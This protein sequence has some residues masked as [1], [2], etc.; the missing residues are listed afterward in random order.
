VARVNVEQVVFTD[1]RYALLGRLIGSDRW[2][3]IGRMTLV[4]HVCQERESYVLTEEVVNSLFDD[5]SRMSEALLT[6]GL[7]K[8]HRFGLY[9]CGTKGRIEWLAKKRDT[10]RKN[11]KL[12]GRPA[13]TEVEPMENRHRFPQETNDKELYISSSLVEE[14]S[15]EKIQVKK[16]NPPVSA[17]EIVEEFTLTE[18]HLEWGKKNCPSVPLEQEVEAWRDRLRSAGYTWGKARIPVKDAQASFYTSCRNAETWGT[19]VPKS[20]GL[21]PAGSNKVQ[22]NFR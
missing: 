17:R 19:Y 13:V 22:G 6:S 11:G 21:Y 1:P 9:I 12:G 18:K 15:R 3:A 4:W 14:T 7:A 10:A 8:K 20:G 16:K 2:G 5:V